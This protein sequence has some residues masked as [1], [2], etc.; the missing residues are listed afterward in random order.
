MPQQAMCRN[1]CTFTAAARVRCT[2]YKHS[3]LWSIQG[4]D[5]TTIRHKTDGIAEDTRLGVLHWARLSHRY[6]RLHKPQ[7][8]AR[9]STQYHNKATRV[10]EPMPCQRPTK[11]QACR[12]S[13][14]PCRGPGSAPRYPQHHPRVRPVH[15]RHDMSPVTGSTSLMVLRPIA[16]ARLP[17]MRR[18][19]RYCRGRS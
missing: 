13:L 7:D 9:H 4:L 16:Q 3:G 18:C 10:R 17:T 12:G 8:T 5:P 1:H 15:W 14:A 11:S 19:Q 2:L 6:R